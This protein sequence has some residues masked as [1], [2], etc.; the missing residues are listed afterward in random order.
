[1]EAQLVPVFACGLLAYLAM[2]PFLPPSLIFAIG[3]NAALY[4][5]MAWTAVSTGTLAAVLAGGGLLWLLSRRWSRWH[6]RFILLLAWVFT[7]VPVLYVKLGFHFLPQ[8]ARYMVEMELALTLLVVF[9]IAPVIDRLPKTARVALAIALLWPAYLQVIHHRR[10]SKN[11]I[12]SVDVT[13][14]IEYQVAKWVERNLPGW[15]VQAPGSIWQW[16]NTFS[17]VPQFAGGSFPTAPNVTQLRAAMQLNGIEQTAIPSI[18]YKAY[19]VDAVIV[20]GIDSPEFWRPHR[21]GHQFDG[22]FPVLW[23]ER[24]TRIYA[25]PRPVRTLAHVIPR[26]VLVSRV[27]AEMSDTAQLEK[28]VAAMEAPAAPAA[29]FAWLNDSRARIHAVC[30]SDDQVLSIQVTYHPGWKAKAGGRQVPISKDALGQIV[31][32][33]NRAG[34]FDI[35]L[36]YDGGLEAMV[37]RVLSAMTLLGVALAI[38]WHRLGLPS[39]QALTRSFHDFDHL[40]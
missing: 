25:V 8:S 15:R 12:Q 19:G 18:W 9:G 26:A 20:P 29:T 34:T 32:Q 10:F 21:A 6:L 13:G 33:P 30:G 35:D 11:A 40:L 22:V 31:L 27:P 38:V 2:C 5:Y 3:S 28:Y 1:M 4:P 23:D 14:T 39:Y 16:L 7:A 17:R 37:C 36:V 24:D